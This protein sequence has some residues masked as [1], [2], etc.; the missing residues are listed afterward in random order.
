MSKDSALHLPPDSFD[1]LRQYSS[2][3][4]LSCLLKWVNNTLWI[5]LR[6]RD[7]GLITLGLQMS[8]KSG[9][10]Q[11]YSIIIIIL[12]IILLWK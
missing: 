12:G 3:S 8:L 2:G 9:I 10:K 7:C 4:G 6:R 5:Q 11:A 1:D